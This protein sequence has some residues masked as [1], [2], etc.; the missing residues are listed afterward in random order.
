MLLPWPARL[1][2]GVTGTHVWVLD[3]PVKYLAGIYDDNAL[4]TGIK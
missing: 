2:S 4:G 3:I 1:N